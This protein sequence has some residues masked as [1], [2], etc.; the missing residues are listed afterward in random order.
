MKKRNWTGY[1]F[2]ITGIILL[3][4]F[5]FLYHMKVSLSSDS[6][7]MF[8]LLKDWLSGNIYLK[9][10]I[11]GTNNFFF[12][13]TIWCIPGILAGLETCSI[14]YFVPSVFYALLVVLCCY[15]F[16]WNHK[17]TVDVI[18]RISCTVGYVASVGMISYGASYTLLNMNS[19]NGLYVFCCIEFILLLKY[20]KENKKGCLTVYAV[21]GILT[22]F[23]DDVILMVLI[24][25]VIVLSLYYLLWNRRKLHR[26]YYLLLFVTGGMFIAAKLCRYL[27]EKGGGLIT[28]GIPVHLVPMSQLYERCKQ[29]F[30]EACILWG[31]GDGNGNIGLIDNIYTIIMVIV[32]L[33]I[34]ISLVIN[35]IKIVHRAV[36][37]ENIFLWLITI[38]NIGACVFTDTAVVYRYLVPAYVFG[39]MLLF[40][41]VM[42]RMQVIFSKNHIRMAGT[43]VAVCGL[44]VISCRMTHIRNASIYSENEIEVAKYLIEHEYGNGYGDFWCASLIS[45]FT[46]FKLNVMPVI[47]REEKLHAYNE[48]IK[49]SW[50]EEEDIHYII[51]KSDDKQNLFCSKKDTVSMLGEPDRD[52]VI[53][54][55]F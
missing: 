42:G 33:G 14:L 31:Y 4:A 12:T 32:L 3:T 6:T 16:I 44:I 23:S 24:A 28:R 7:T 8:P 36:S 18:V 25:P 39:T 5:Y 27:L 13:E 49:V 1:G 37:V 20:I 17:E 45:C 53:E 15:I 19:H 22:A 40:T 48:L 55:A 30:F 51:V 2:F 54:K 46:D 47:A 21:I 43:A 38:F 34:L 35:F 26:K 9:D 50:Y 52:I 29:Y 11:V 41:T 10:W